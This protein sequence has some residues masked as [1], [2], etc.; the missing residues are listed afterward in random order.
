MNNFGSKSNS[1]N[2][3]I[4]FNDFS[5][6]A[7]KSNDLTTFEYIM[8]KR[9]RAEELKKKIKDIEEKIRIEEEKLTRGG[10]QLSVNTT[11]QVLKRPDKNS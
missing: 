9:E 7:I 8:Q 2:S 3:I 5:H 10:N 11:E 6:M 4:K 1:Y